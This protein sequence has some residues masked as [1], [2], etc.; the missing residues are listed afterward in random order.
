MKS[1]AYSLALSSF[2]VTISYIPYAASYSPNN[3]QV[4]I[5]TMIEKKGKGNRVGDLST[6]NLIE[7]DFNFNNKVLARELLKS[8]EENNL[9]PKE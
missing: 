1:Y 8:I 3:W 2:E 9:L 5:N 7:V 6:I 4:S